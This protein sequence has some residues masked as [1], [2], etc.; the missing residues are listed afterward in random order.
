MTTSHK[1]FISYYHEDQ[2]YK[3][4]FAS[5][6]DNYIVDR[7]VEDGDID[8][9]NH[10]DTIFRNIREDFIADATVTVVLIG[11]CTWQRKYVDWE[12][13][14]SLRDTVSN[15]RCGLLGVLLPTHRDYLKGTYHLGLI[16][17][18]LAD[19]CRGENPFAIIH[20]WSD[21][22]SEIQNWIHS[23]FLRRDKVLPN[24]GRPRFIYN[25]GGSC[26]AGW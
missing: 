13:G 9:R 11:A 10:V 18:R 20:D 19:N 26:S 3:D 25:S 2:E 1:V 17:P 12:I 5:L 8:E 15:S 16:P 14:S 7:S 23:A 4:W 22:A 24:N 6:M 21:R